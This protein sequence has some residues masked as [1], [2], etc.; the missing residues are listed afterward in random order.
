MRFTDRSINALKP[1]A[2][3]YTVW[4]DGR[5]GLGVRISPRG[6][7]SWIYMYRFQ[8]KARPEGHTP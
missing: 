1:E 5:T 3:R 2:E 7:K 6:R 8:G 4:E